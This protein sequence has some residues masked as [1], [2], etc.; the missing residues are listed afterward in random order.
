MPGR[1]VKEMGWLFWS[2]VVPAYELPGW[3]FVGGVGGKFGVDDELVEGI[4]G[5]SC[6]GLETRYET[7]GWLITGAEDGDCIPSR[8][9]GS[10]EGMLK[11]S[12]WGVVGLRV[13]SCA[14]LVAVYGVFGWLYAGA[15]VARV[16]YD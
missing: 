4:G 2:W 6:I 15:E 12:D 1:F 14:G 13:F 10:A 8:L 11:E 3:I 5:L 16:A 7:F 9:L